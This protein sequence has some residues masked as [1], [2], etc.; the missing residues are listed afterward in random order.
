MSEKTFM[1]L[2]L[3]IPNRNGNVY[4]KKSIEE[5]ISKFKIPSFGAFM[6]NG[7]ADIDNFSHVVNRVWIENDV[8]MATVKTI[9]T[10]KGKVLRNLLDVDAVEFRTSGT[11]RVDE[12]GIVSDYTMISVSAVAKGTG[13]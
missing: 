3:D 4:T 12:N 5:A 2:Q 8:V 7:P 13:A 6:D 11:G 9:D 10:P 1:V